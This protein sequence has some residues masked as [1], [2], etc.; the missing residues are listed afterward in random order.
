MTLSLSLSKETM[1]VEDEDQGVA[2]IVGTMMENFV[3]FKQDLDLQDE[4]TQTWLQKI[5]LWE[6]A[7]LPWDLWHQNIYAKTQLEM[8]KRTDGYLFNNVKLTPQ[9][10]ATIFKLN[11]EEGWQLPKVTDSTMKKEF[12]PPASSQ[13]LL[14]TQECGWA[15][16]SSAQ[17]VHGKGISFNEV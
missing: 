2:E 16:E 9:L 6:F 15:E 17:M 8:L 4:D 3:T 5:G 12:G 7:N 10:V 13:K 14:S 11:Y 1:E